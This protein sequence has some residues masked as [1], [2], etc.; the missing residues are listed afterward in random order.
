MPAVDLDADLIPGTSAAGWRIGARLAECREL[1]LGAT[2]VQY[3]PGFHLNS[4]ISGNAGVLVVRDSFPEGSGNTTVYFGADIVRFNFN[5]AG[6]LFAIWTF[7]GYWGRVFDRIGIGS[8][9]REVRAL[10]PVFYDSGDEMYYPDP[11]QSPGAPSGIAF[12]AA[13][14]EELEDTPICGFCVHDWDLM[15]RSLAG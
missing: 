12:D 10:F 8:Q 1:L 15:R 13:E 7:E 3:H 5:A 9:L 11:E 2:E 6:E 14:E 4:A